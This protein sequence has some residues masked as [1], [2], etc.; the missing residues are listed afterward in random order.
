MSTALTQVGAPVPG[1]ASRP[2][3]GSRAAAQQAFAAPADDP[4]RAELTRK[5]QPSPDAS[6]VRHEVMHEHGLDRV[7]LFHLGPI[8]RLQAEVAIASATAVRLSQ[9]Q[10]KISGAFLDVRD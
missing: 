6:Q 9:M 3:E 1:Q 7:T 5:V 2:A 10:P 4:V 8:D